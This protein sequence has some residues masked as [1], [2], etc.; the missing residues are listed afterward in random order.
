MDGEANIA[1]FSASWPEGRA[2]GRR[3]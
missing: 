3:E 2:P 1:R